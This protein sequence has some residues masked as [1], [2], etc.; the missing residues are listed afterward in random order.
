MSRLDSRVCV[1]LRTYGNRKWFAALMPHVA[2]TP[3]LGTL[4]WPTSVAQSP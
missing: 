4:R 1:F 3:K 2:G